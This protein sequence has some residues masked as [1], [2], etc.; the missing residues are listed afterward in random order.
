MAQKAMAR[1]TGA[2]ALR[3]VMDE[4]MLDLMYD[5]PDISGDAA[6][7]VIDGDSVD[8]PPQ[9]ADL[10]IAQKESA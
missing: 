7:Y 9:L 4:L 3:S 10:G 8:H 5:L 1:E 6:K 2:R